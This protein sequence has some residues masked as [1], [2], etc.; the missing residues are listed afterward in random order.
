MFQVENGKAIRTLIKI[1]TRNGQFVQVLKKQAPTANGKA[2]VWEDF[3]GQEQI[4]A[5]NVASLADRQ[6]ISVEQRAKN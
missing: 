2:A 4:V 5:S 6:A 3:T 1:G